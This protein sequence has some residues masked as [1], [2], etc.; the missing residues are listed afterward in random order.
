MVGKVPELL[1]ISDRYQ[2]RHG[3]EQVAERAFAAGLRNFVLRDKDLATT[4]RRALAER[5]CELA[6][7]HLGRVLING[8]WSLA[9]E[10][11]AAGVHLQQPGDIPLARAALGDAAVIGVSAHSREALVAAAA[12]GVDYATLSPVFATES[13]PGYGPPLELEGLRRLTDGIAPPVLALGGVTVAN[14]RDCLNAGAIGIAVMGEVMRAE[15]PEEV[16][17]QL[18]QAIRGS[19]PGT[20]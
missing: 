3:L 4:E 7:T 17:R 11:G 18:L 15:A 9:A 20:P 13:K 10:V 12:E 8:D 6:R 16:V 5:L 14:A 19:A 2:A 1:V